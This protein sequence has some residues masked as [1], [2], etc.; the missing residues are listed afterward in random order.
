VLGEAAAGGITMR[1]GDVFMTLSTKQKGAKIS[2][3]GGG[4]NIEFTDGAALTE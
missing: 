4:L 1:K 2:A 3:G